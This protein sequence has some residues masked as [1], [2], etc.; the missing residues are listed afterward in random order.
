M[1]FSNLWTKEEMKQPKETFLC[2]KIS[3]RSKL[4]AMDKKQPGFLKNSILNKNKGK[5][6]FKKGLLKKFPKDFKPEPYKAKESF[7]S[8]VRSCIKKMSDVSLEDLRELNIFNE[9]DDIGVLGLINPLDWHTKDETIL[10]QMNDAYKGYNPY[11]DNQVSIE[12][13]YIE[14]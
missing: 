12:Q 6:T 13:N 10:T 4:Y 3:L 8:V 11:P 9:I 2:I 7:T 14:L 1:R 5:E